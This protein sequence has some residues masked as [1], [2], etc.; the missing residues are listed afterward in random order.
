[1]MYEKEDDIKDFQ[2]AVIIISDPSYNHKY[3][4]DVA[5]D[6]I[7]ETVRDNKDDK[8]IFG[9]IERLDWH[10]RKFAI[11]YRIEDKNLLNIKF[12]PNTDKRII[13]RFIGS[14]IHTSPK[15]VIVFRDNNVAD[16]SSEL[17][18]RCVASGIPV[19]TVDSYG[20]KKD[21]TQLSVSDIRPNYYYKE[22]AYDFKCNDIGGIYRR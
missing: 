18:D 1:M 13:Q 10:V 8:F 21:L 4:I 6:K 20:N 16:I 9:I 7:F 5:I 2:H 22:R 17:I 14:L 12:K 3:G 19:Q 15:K 11:E